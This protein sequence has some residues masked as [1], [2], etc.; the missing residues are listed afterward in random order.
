MLM[1]EYG[2][3]RKH[4]YWPAGAWPWKRPEA[5]PPLLAP[6]KLPQACAAV[7][8]KDPCTGAIPWTPAVQV[9]HRLRLPA[10]TPSHQPLAVQMLLC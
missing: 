6:G 4:L 8:Q 3:E 9:R 5:P 7:L 10:R 2:M 1:W